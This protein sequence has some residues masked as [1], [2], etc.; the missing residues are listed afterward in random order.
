MVNIPSKDLEVNIRLS[1]NLMIDLLRN[2]DLDSVEGDA[3]SNDSSLEDMLARIATGN[4]HWKADIVPNLMQS[5]NDSIVI[6]SSSS[7]EPR[8]RNA[9]SERY[10]KHNDECTHS[11]WHFFLSQWSREHP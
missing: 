3:P 10:S 4:N 2:G 9:M 11:E 5:D 8:D 1:D 7:N 6:S